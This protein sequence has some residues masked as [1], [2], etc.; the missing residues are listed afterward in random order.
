MYGG[1]IDART[2]QQSWKNAKVEETKTIKHA[3]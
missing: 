1:I 2:L 3:E